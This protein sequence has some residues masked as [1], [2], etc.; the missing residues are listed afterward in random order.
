VGWLS[1]PLVK[2]GVAAPPIL[3][4]VGLGVAEPP[5]RAKP[6]YFIFFFLSLLPLGVVRPHEWFSHP[7]GQTPLIFFFFFLALLPH[8]LNSLNYFFSCSFALGK[9]PPMAK[10]PSFFFFLLFC[11]WIWPNHPHGLQG[12]FSHPKTGQGSHHFF[13]FF[14]LFF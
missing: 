3:A 6:P 5:L 1:Q 7:K 4:M 10:P 13:F 9:P 8:G 14:F 11:P 2:M 12:W